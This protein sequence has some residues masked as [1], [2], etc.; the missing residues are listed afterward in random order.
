MVEYPIAQKIVLLSCLLSKISR[1][2]VSRGFTFAWLS[3]PRDF[4]D[5]ASSVICDIGSL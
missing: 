1:G 2:V 3:A 4:D 5:E